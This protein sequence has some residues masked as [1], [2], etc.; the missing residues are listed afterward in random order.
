MHCAAS[1][2]LAPEEPVNMSRTLTVPAPV[3]VTPTV[4]VRPRQGPK[5]A[6]LIAEPNTARAYGDSDLV[7]VPGSAYA[8]TDGDPATAWTAP[9]RVVQYKTPATLTLMAALLS[10]DWAAADVSAPEARRES[11]GLTAAF[12]QWHLERG[13]R[14]LSLVDR[15]PDP[16]KAR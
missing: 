1:M 11:S 16:Q 8:A 15:T 6:D 14:S 3:S 13:I 9:Q 4:W 7:E 10:G 12:L 5:L 2:A